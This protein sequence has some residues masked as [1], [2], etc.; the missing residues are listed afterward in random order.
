M[1]WNQSCFR[2][3]RIYRIARVFKSLRGALRELDGFYDKLD[4]Q[5]LMEGSTYDCTRTTD[6][7]SKTT[8]KFECIR[9]LTPLN[10]TPFLVRL[11]SSGETVVVKFV[12][13]F[14]VDAHQLPA[15]DKLHELGY[16][17]CDLRPPEVVFAGTKA[18]LIYFRWAGKLFI[19]LSSEK[20]HNLT[21]LN[22]YSVSA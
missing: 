11:E 4:K 6:P 3:E 10:R 13:R 1:V 7:R 22:H 18:F 14:G 9:S 20:E 19:Q 17:F 2:G 5:E 12:A 15:E 21:L 16:V 8:E